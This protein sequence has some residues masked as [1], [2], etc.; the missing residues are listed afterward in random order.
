MPSAQQV[1]DDINSLPEGVAYGVNSQ[2]SDQTNFDWNM[3]YQYALAT[4]KRQARFS[5]GV[6]TSAA[7]TWTTAHIQI[8]PQRW[9]TLVPW[10][11]IFEGP[12]HRANNVGVRF[13]NGIFQA[14]RF[15]ATTWDTILDRSDTSY[16]FFPATK[17]AVLSTGGSAQSRADTDGARIVHYPRG[18]LS[19]VIHMVWRVREVDLYQEYYEGVYSAHTVQLVPWD[20]NVLFDDNLADIL[21]EIGADY[22]PQ[23]V[24]N[25]GGSVPVV[26][27]VFISKM[28]KLSNTPRRV[29]IANI[30][31]L[32]TNSTN[33]PKAAGMSTNRFINSPPDT[34][35]GA[36]S[37]PGPAPA[38]APTPTPAPAPTPPPATVDTNN[39]VVAT[40]N[41]TNHV[42]LIGAAS[43]PTPVPTPSPTPTPTPT[44]APAPS[45]LATP[46]S[47]HLTLASGAGN[48]LVRALNGQPQAN[49]EASIVDTAVAT[50]PA[51]TDFDGRFKVT[52]VALGVTSVTFTVRAAFYGAVDEVTYPPTTITVPITV[53]AGERPDSGVVELEVDDVT[54]VLGGAPTTLTILDDNGEALT[55]GMD[56]TYSKPRILAGPPECVGGVLRVY[57]VGVG[58]GTITLSYDDPVAGNTTKI[59]LVTVTR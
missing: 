49:I 47:L 39:W 30:D 36:G 13:S 12:N 9:T 1:V 6:N 18:P 50:G 15:G 57:A 48:V 31:V 38:P 43:S 32:E 14:L 22:Y 44:P 7:L 17:S 34:D 25:P 10:G 33:Q 51:T 27:N 55:R 46:V 24:A 52:P 54:I 11:V 29:R 41:G 3:S 5:V 40:T 8:Y 23:G 53:T 59:V 16:S 2:T 26:P 45:L 56:V 19:Y 20:P 21:L 58:S 35:I 37:A 28:N 4:G 42:Y